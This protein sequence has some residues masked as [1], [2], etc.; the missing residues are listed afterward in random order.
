MQEGREEGPP[1]HD[2]LSSAHPIR[3]QGVLGSASVLPDSLSRSLWFQ[4]LAPGKLFCTFSP[5]L[6]FHRLLI[7]KLFLEEVGGDWAPK[8]LF[9]R[10]HLGGGVR[11]Q[12][13]QGLVVERRR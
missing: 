1:S 3:R 6:E 11:E 12:F 2:D 13:I 9:H 7:F 10:F 8:G 4:V 5:W